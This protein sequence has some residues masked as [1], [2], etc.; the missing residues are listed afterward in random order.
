MLEEDLLA[1]AE[2]TTKVDNTRFQSTDEVDVLNF[3]LQH[4]NMNTK[5]K[6]EG[7][8]RLSHEYLQICGE[9]RESQDI[10]PSEFDKYQS[11]FLLS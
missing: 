7:E 5:R 8:I 11:R 10:H 4:E 9:T 2:Q 1:M 3:V 6:T